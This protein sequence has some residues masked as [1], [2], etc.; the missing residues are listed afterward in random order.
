MRENGIKHPDITLSTVFMERVRDTGEEF[1]NPVGDRRVRFGNVAL[2]PHN[3]KVGG[4]VE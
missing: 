2:K 4:K 1:I 3:A